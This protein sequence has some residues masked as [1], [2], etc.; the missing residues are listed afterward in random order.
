MTVNN[1]TLDYSASNAALPAGNY[2]I[3]GGT[4]NIGTRTKTIEAFHLDRRHGQRQ[5]GTLTS[6]AGLRSSGRHGRR[7]LRQHQRRSD[8]DDAGNGFAHPNLPA[9][10]YSISDG[11]LNINGL[12]KTT[13]GTLQMSGGTLSGTAPPR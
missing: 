7:R 9:G 12:S 5:P 10:N 6:T 2:T 1:G 11:T 8:E 13:N 4:L 3:N